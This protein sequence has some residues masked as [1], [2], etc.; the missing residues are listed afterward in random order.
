MAKP[1]RRPRDPNQLANFIVKA[2]TG[3]LPPEPEDKRHPGAVALG[4]LGGAKGGTA[5]AKSL[6]PKR[7]KAI[8]KRAAAA[9]WRK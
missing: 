8:A 2:A 9:R 3:E 6:S 1:P 7:R 4:R 5:R